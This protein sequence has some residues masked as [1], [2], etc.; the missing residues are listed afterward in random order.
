[1]G[2]KLTQLKGRNASE[3][4]RI[5]RMFAQTRE[6]LVKNISPGLLREI[7]E[8]VLEAEKKAK[9]APAPTPAPEQDPES[10]LEPPAD[11]VAQ[12]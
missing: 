3:Q 11:A 8:T 4:A 9:A 10:A 7:E 2:R 1:M 5:D 6:M 12:D